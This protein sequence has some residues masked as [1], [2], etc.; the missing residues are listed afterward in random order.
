M[1]KSGGL[2]DGAN[3]LVLNFSAWLLLNGSSFKREG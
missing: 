3:E 2:K 1:R